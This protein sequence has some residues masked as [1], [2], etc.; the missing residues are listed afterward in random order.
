MSL[1]GRRAA[2]LLPL[3]AAEFAFAQAPAQNRLWF[4]P[5]QLPRFT[6][7]VERYL[8]SPAGGVDSL[9]MREGVQLIFP[10]DTGEAIRSAVPAGRPI[11]V[12]G[13]RARSAPVITILAWATT[14]EEE[15]RFVE[16]PSWWS[17]TTAPGQARIAASGSV[18]QPLHNTRG[19]VNGALLEDG[20]VVRVPAEVAAARAELF[21]Q[22]ARLAATGLGVEGEGG[23]ALFAESLGDNPQSMTPVAPAPGDAGA[24]SPRR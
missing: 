8:P 15:P 9:I 7:T 24:A 10:A 19:E 23:R 5:T 11:L 1:I 21:R 2:L 13:I 17:G 6:G 12:W 14:P 4:D 16:R 20:T 22:G 3:L 18:R